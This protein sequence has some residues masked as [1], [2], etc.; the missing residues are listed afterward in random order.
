MPLQK[1]DPKKWRQPWRHNLNPVKPL[2]FIQTTPGS[3]VHLVVFVP[4]TTARQIL[5]LNHMNRKVVGGKHNDLVY[6]LDV[7][8]PNLILLVIQKKKFN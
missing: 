4:T 3:L 7:S 2:C 8:A 5:F 6:Y 1:I